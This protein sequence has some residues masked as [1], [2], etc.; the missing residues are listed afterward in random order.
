MLIFLSYMKDCVKRLQ[1]FRD[2]L[3]KKTKLSGQNKECVPDLI[4]KDNKLY[5]QHTTY[6]IIIFGGAA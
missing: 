5:K 6:L 2:D 4:I 3:P 1:H